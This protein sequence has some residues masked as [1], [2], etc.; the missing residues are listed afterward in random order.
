MVDLVVVVVV[1]VDCVIENEIERAC[2]SHREEQ[3]CE[4]MHVLC[5]Y[6]CVLYTCVSVSTRRVSCYCLTPS[7]PVRL[8]E[9]GVQGEEQIHTHMNDE[10][11]AR[12]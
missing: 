9:G 12:H 4:H 10:Y 11:V 6:P 5:V 7:Q 8:S 2:D 1:V 3:I